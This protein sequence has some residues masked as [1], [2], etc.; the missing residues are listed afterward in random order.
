MNNEISRTGNIKLNWTD[1][2]KALK[3]LVLTKKPELMY[4]YLESKGDLYAP[5]ANSVVKGDSFSG[6]FALNSLEEVTIENGKK[7]NEDKVNN[8]RFDMAY[9]YL[10][11]LRD[12]FTEKG[13]EIK[14]DITHEEA[15]KFHERVFNKYG[16]PAEA[17][18]L[19]PVFDV[20]PNREI[21]EVYW[22]KALGAVGNTEKEAELS[23][24]TLNIM[25]ES[26]YDAPASKQPQ[27]HRWLRRVVNID[28][29]VDGVTI[30]LKKTYG[31][32]VTPTIKTNIDNINA[33]VYE[34]G[35]SLIDRGTNRFSFW[36]FPFDDN[37][38]FSIQTDWRGET[39]FTHQNPLSE[40]Y[41]E[42]PD[43][44]LPK[45]GLFDSPSVNYQSNIAHYDR[46]IDNLRENMS[47][48]NNSISSFDDRYSIPSIPSVPEFSYRGYSSGASFNFN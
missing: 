11:T 39:E 36:N 46:M 25:F 19:Q 24:S 17:R 44:I 21:R 5:L 7:F 35:N 6:V 41:L 27:I 48:M 42:K 20:L 43:Y 8:I 1:T 33:L 14:G 32:V 37:S 26:L 3:I 30:S 2:S 40:Y 31:S 18:T 13:I 12:R 9:G 23:L 47:S 28:N 22:Q 10:K 15:M 34:T 4:E 45:T 16:L 38:R 29:A